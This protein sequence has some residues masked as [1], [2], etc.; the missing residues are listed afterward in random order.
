[1]IKEN[2][3]KSEWNHSDLQ[4]GYKLKRERERERE[5]EILIVL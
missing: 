5:K 3:K 2:A 1:M 4:D